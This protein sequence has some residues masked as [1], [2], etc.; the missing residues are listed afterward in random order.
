V[1]LLPDREANTLAAWLHAHPG[2][3]VIARD[4]AGKS[5]RIEIEWV[6]WRHPPQY[7]MTEPSPAPMSDEMTAT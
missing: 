2:V 6:G 4:R 5:I 3:A 1:A 7:A